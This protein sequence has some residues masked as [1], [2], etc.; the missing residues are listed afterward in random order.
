M[1][2]AADDLATALAVMLVAAVVGYVLVSDE[3]TVLEGEQN[4]EPQLR[5]DYVGKL[6]RPS[7]CPSCASKRVRSRST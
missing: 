1:A 5:S 6:A 7:T 3:Q 2:A 4:R